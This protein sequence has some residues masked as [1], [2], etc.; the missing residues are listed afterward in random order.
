MIKKIFKYTPIVLLLISASVTDAIAQGSDQQMVDS[1]A[2]DMLEVASV[3][4]HL[5]LSGTT[6]IYESTAPI[7][8]ITGEELMRYP[9]TNLAEALVGKIPSGKF[10]TTNYAPGATAVSMTVR[11]FNYLVLVDGIKRPLNS[12]TAE[13]VESV[14]VIRGM[15]AR[16]MYG[17]EAQNGVIV[18]K[19]KRG[20][21]G[22][23]VIS[24]S[25]EYGAKVIN[26]KYLPEWLGSHDYAKLYNETALND[27][28][29]DA[30]YSPDDLKGYA[31]GN[32]LRYPDEDLYGEMF[33]NS[34][35]YKQANMQITGGS[36]ST[37]YFMNVNYQGEG[38]GMLQHKD[39]D[40]HKLR[41]R[42]NVDMDVTED[43]K[44]GVDAIGSLELRNDPLD[45]GGIWGAIGNYPSNAYPIE[46]APD[47]FG[48]HASYPNNPV[49]NLIKRDMKQRMDRYGQFNMNFEY[50]FGKL[51]KGLEADAYLTSD[52]FHYQNMATKNGYE[53]P[54][55][56]VEWVPTSDTS[57]LMVLIPNGNEVPA[58]GTSKIGDT[59]NFQL[60]GYFN[61][62]YNRSFGGHDVIGKFNYF[63][64]H[65]TAKG[66]VQPFK[67]QDMSFTGAYAYNKKYYADLILSYTGIMNLPTDSRYKL[68]PTV[69]LGWIMSEESFMKDVSS[70]DFLK[71]RASYGMM[72]NYTG[73]DY[74]LYNTEWES[75]NTQRFGSYSD[76]V[77]E[78]LPTV[79]TKQNGNADLT[80]GTTTEFDMGIDGSFLD[81]RLTMQLDYY[82][83]IKDGLVAKALTPALMGLTNYYDNI[84]ENMY[85]GVDGYIR[86]SDRVGDLDYAVG[87]N[88]GYNVSEVIK[89][90]SPEYEYSWMNRMGNPTDAI[91]G[92]VDQGL[93][94]DDNDIDNSAEQTFGTVQPGNIKYTNLN[95]DD[96]NMI[97]GVTDAKM[98]GHST[99]RFKYG[100]DLSLR[101]KG[102][103]F[104]VIGY[105][106]SSRDINVK[107][108]RYFHTDSKNKYSAYVQENRWELA[109]PNPNALHPRMTTATSPND[110][111]TSTYWLRDA[112]FFKIKNME[113]AYNLPQSV[114]HQL[115]LKNLKVFVR[116]TN[117][118]TVSKM[119]DLDP[120]SVAMGV[121]NYPSMQTFTGGLS[122]KF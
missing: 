95:P 38:K 47:T 84:S 13:E 26:Q 19:T 106:I 70:I 59:Y 69:G 6:N 117:L 22:D 43:F 34:M 41:F 40:Y 64:Q 87:F 8:V 75:G 36:E 62:A 88:G 104:Y 31:Q 102:F 72:G 89:N 101:Y 94:V 68:F 33:N 79:I 5:P 90:S 37:R 63:A 80:W 27:G 105:G 48:M 51:V 53:Y 20:K 76:N 115:K 113:L 7:T 73:N 116:G 77:S 16:A 25:V 96:D 45:I 52:V 23:R 121:S 42:S 15:S 81:Q 67:R 39:K 100:L 12:L 54:K 65:K 61:I 108:N 118:L 114:V 97:D 91:Y 92:L 85:Q 35:Q 44:I 18:V 66:Q 74:F 10:F 110:N 21:V 24:A 119:K 57:E 58:T 103:E 28:I 60:A 93:F 111:Q 112:S 107:G 78:S 14:S 4:A 83:M 109:N 17:Y 120:E 30:P 82:Y 2:T 49:A 46:I 1:L 29:E 9:T 55:Y 98:I 11:D 71:L 122:V 86:Y 99:P 50:D 32:T 56:Q 3:E